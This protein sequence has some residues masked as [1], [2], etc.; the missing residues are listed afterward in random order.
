MTTPEEYEPE[1]IA[2]IKRW[3]G[4]TSRGVYPLGP[5]LPAV[6]DPKVSEEEKS[7]SMRGQEISQF[8][9]SVLKSHGP[10]SMIYVCAKISRQLYLLTTSRRLHLDPSFGQLN[11]RRFGL[12][13]MFS[14]RRQS[15]S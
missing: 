7:I 8:M 1:A 10:Q 9:D 12:S 13:S 11:P 15:L 4:K 2:D 5:L 3:F 6:N 14:W